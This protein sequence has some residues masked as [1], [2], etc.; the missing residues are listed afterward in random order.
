LLSILSFNQ[1]FRSWLINKL[2]RLSIICCEINL[3]N[4]RARPR[5]IQ[6]QKKKNPQQQHFGREFFRGNF[7][8]ESHLH[9]L[10][11]TEK[12][13]RERESEIRERE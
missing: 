5:K 12:K 6:E 7:L 1:N 9:E 13:E 3:Y 10:S 4:K 2:F 8:S 11:L